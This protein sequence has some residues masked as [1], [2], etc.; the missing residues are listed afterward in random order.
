[1]NQFS[2]DVPD[3][4]ICDP[5]EAN[6]EAT[7][8]ALVTI[9]FRNIELSATLRDFS[10]AL[11]TSS[12][13]LAICECQGAEDAIFGVIQS[14]RRGDLRHNP[15]L[16]LIVTSGIESRSLMG[17]AMDSGADDFIGR[18]I[19]AEILRKRIGALMEDRKGFIIGRDYVG[20]VRQSDHNLPLLKPFVSPNSLRLKAKDRLDP[21]T[22]NMQLARELRLGRH[23][24]ETRMLWCDA[25][26]ICVR[27]KLAAEYAPAS[28][29]QL[30]N[31][32]KVN[33]L[34]RAV[35]TRV[36]RSRSQ[37]VAEYCKTML[38]EIGALSKS[39]ANT[40]AK[41]LGQAAWNLYHC[42]DPALP[43]EEYCSEVAATAVLIGDNE[44]SENS[45]TYRV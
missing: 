42:L 41:A 17:R 20:P 22:I 43:F 6:R 40:D 15:F 11:A 45:R 34:A 39:M 38:S 33:A 35:E 37:I 8:T 23:R 31:F 1:M 18:P 27:L 30:E 13:D 32:A 16:V 25:F 26:Q 28:T 24:L 19:S 14:L 3:V 9:G 12:F 29:K 4:L 21:A 2:Y 36:Q 5:I 10:N 44:R 7:R